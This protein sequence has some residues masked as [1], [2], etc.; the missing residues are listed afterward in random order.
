MI[1]PGDPIRWPADLT[2]QVDYEAELAVVIG[3][4]TQRVAEAER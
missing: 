3:R 1:A 4:T 2:E